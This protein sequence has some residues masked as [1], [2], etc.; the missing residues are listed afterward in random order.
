MTTFQ[1]GWVSSFFADIAA[2]Y[3][4][5]ASPAAGTA[6][7]APATGMAATAPATV[8]VVEPTWLVVS[9]A[10]AGTRSTL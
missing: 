8:S 2:N 10:F 9:H 4:F 1:G 6:A 5:A 3:F 7:A